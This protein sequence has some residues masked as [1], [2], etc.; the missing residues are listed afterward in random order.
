MSYDAIRQQV[1]DA[2]GQMM[3]DTTEMKISILKY[4]LLKRCV[5]LYCGSPPPLGTGQALAPASAII[6]WVRI[7]PELI[8]S[9]IN[10]I[11]VENP[12]VGFQK[13]TDDSVRVYLKP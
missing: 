11:Q 4:L 3:Q 8:N 7:S 1:R 9:V 12:N 10:E 6:E 13:V 2:A 5:I